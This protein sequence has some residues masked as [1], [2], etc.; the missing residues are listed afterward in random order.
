MN[1]LDAMCNQK[2]KTRAEH[3]A[4]RGTGT[5]LVLDVRPEPGARAVFRLSGGLTYAEALDLTRDAVTFK[6][7][8]HSLMSTD[9]VAQAD[10]SMACPGTATCP[11][12]CAC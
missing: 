12:P 4:V 2:N 5:L 8:P 9:A 1:L 6:W 11:D 3:Q 7:I 10:C